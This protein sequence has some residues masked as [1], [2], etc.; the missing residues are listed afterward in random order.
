MTTLNE[1]VDFN[2]DINCDCAT[3]VFC[4]YN[5]DPDFCDCEA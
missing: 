2:T 1:M 3:C 5:T 4:D